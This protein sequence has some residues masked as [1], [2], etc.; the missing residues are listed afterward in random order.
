M[1]RSRS[2]SLAAIFAVVF[3]DLLGFGIALPLL[4]RYGEYFDA[5]AWLGPLVAVFSAMQFFFA[6]VW[7]RL[8]D[9]I[10]RRPVLL[11]GLAGSAVFYSLFGFASGMERNATLLGLTPL[12]LLFVSRI[13]AGIAGATIPTA[14]AYIADVTGPAE[15]AKGMALIGAAFGM[16]FTFGPMIGAAFV[17]DDPAAPPSPYPGYLAAG[18]SA[19]AFL[20]A[21]AVLREPE[22]HA[23][24]A[25]ARPAG[26]RHLLRDGVRMSLVGLIFLTTTAFAMFESTLTLFSDRLGY[27]ARENFYLFAFVGITLT[28]AQGVLVRRLA[29]QLKELRMVP[30]GLLFL[31]IG[32]AGLGAVGTM[33]ASDPWMLCAA[34]TS[35]IIGVSFVTPSLQ[36]LLSLTTPGSQQGTVLGFGQSAAALARIVGP[37]AGIWLFQRSIPTAYGVAALVTLAGLVAIVPVLGKIRD[38]ATEQ[39]EAVPPDL[40]T[41]VRTIVE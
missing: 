26:R 10:G 38:R 30:V 13:G 28:I 17:S 22:R 34:L 23:A 7:G 25:S 19:T 37:L 1:T 36:S 32:L 24:T 4:A 18:L 31:A 9:R 6:P 16:G 5:R 35:C 2:A 39:P 15:R 33:R 14:Q 3:I 8:S 21:F 12:A 27:S 20:A 29:P 41:P 11:I 40:G